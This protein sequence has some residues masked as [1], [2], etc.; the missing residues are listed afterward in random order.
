MPLFVGC[1]ALAFPRLA[2]VAVWLLGGDYLMR[3]LGGLGWIVL[4]LL[5]MPVTTLAFAFA[6]N[7][8]APAGRVPDLGW[9]VVGVAALIDLGIIGSNSRR[10]RRKP[11][12]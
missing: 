10:R 11:N 6:V 1:L 8:M 7:S 3:A 4:G 5:F 9:V 2:V 12:D